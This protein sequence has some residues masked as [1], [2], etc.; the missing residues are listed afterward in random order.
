MVELTVL[1][2]NCGNSNHRGSRHWFDAASQAEHQVLAIQEPYFNKRTRSTYCPPG[3]TLL[4]EPYEA[5]RVCFMVSKLV[6]PTH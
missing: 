3:F 4:Y 1:Q 2:Y 6:D 5:T